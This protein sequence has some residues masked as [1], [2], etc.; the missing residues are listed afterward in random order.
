M[1]P[2]GRHGQLLRVVGGPAGE[3]HALDGKDGALV[4]V[5]VL[6][7]FLGGREPRAPVGAIRPPLGAVAEHARR[8]AVKGRR[9]LA[10]AELGHGGAAAG[11]DDEDLLLAPFGRRARHAGLVVGAAVDAVAGQFD[12]ALAAASRRRGRR[13]AVFVVLV[14][15]VVFAVFACVFALIVRRRRG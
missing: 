3:V 4:R 13:F 6:D 15:L 1:R 8:Q 2:P 12:D 9:Q 7:P 11:T 10:A 5:K 14:V